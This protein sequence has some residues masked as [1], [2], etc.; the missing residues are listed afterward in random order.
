M[1]V[2]LEYIHHLTGPVGVLVNGAHLGFCARH[3]N[4]APLPGKSKE[5][6][7]LRHLGFVAIVNSCDRELRLLVGLRSQLLLEC[8]S[9]WVVPRAA[10]SVQHASYRTHANP[11]CVTYY[12]KEHAK[13]VSSDGTERPWF[14][15]QLSRRGRSTGL[16]A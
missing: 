16:C 13:S 11:P 2:V 4:W 14:L 9:V 15:K 1:T 3:A 7:P 8:Y 10:P 12:W 5:N 6:R